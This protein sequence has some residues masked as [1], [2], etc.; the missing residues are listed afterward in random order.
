MASWSFWIDRGGTFTDTVALS[1]SG[2]LLSSKFLSV[3]PKKYDDAAVHSIRNFLSIP[4][5]EKI[6]ISQIESIKMGT[7]VATNALLERRGAR[8][9]L[10]VTRGFEDQLRLGYQ[11]RPDIFARQIILPDQLYE[12]VVTADERILANGKITKSLDMNA[13]KEDLKG[14][15]NEGMTSCAIIL[16]HGYRFV[17]HEK[18]AANLANE[19]GF[20]QVSVSHEVNPQ[21]RFVERGD[22][23]VLDAYLTPILRKY[24]DQLEEN[25]VGDLGHR[26]MFMQSNGGLASPKFF[27]GKDAVLSG[28]AG[29]VVG[30]VEVSMR[31]GEVKIIGFDM[32]GTST[33][34]CHFSGQYE[35]I[36]KGQIAGVRLATPMM[37]IHTV[38]AGGGS[39]LSYSSGRLQVGPESA[40][41]EPGPAC[42]GNG[43]PLTVTDANVITGRLRPEFFPPIFG[44]LGDQSLSKNESSAAIEPIAKKLNKSPEAIAEDWLSVAVQNMVSAIKRVSVQRGYNVSTYCLTV[45][46]G[47]G[48]Q[49]ACSIADKLG[50]NRCLLHSKASLL[51]AY[52]IGLAR[53]RRVKKKT[54]E[55]L[56]TDQSV[57][58]LESQ[59][60]ILMQKLSSEL[61]DQG[62]KMTEIESESTIFLKLK[63]SDTTFPTNFESAQI[64]RHDFEQSFEK[65]FGFSIEDESIMIDSVSVEVCQ[66]KFEIE[67]IPQKPIKRTK[68]KMKAFSTER[69]FIDGKWHSCKFIRKEDLRSNDHVSGPA[70]IIE[71]FTSILV[72]PGWDANHIDDGS[73]FLRKREI[74]RTQH[75]K[76]TKSKPDPMLL[77]VFN[78][79][80]MSIAEQMGVV[81]ENTA[82]SVTIKERL[83]FSCAVFDSSGNLIANAPHMPVHVGSMEASIKAVIK[84]NETI[85]EQDIFALNAPYDGGTHLPDITVVKPVFNQS[86]G[87]LIFFVASRGHHTDVGGSTPGSMPPDS[88][89]IDDEGVYIENFKLVDRGHFKR[90]EVMNIFLGAKYPARSIEVNI[91]DLRAQVAA[92]EKGEKELNLLIDEYGS[93]LVRA[94][95]HFVSENASDMVK[96]ILY[97]IRPSSYVYKMDD[98]IDGNQ[99]QICVSVGLQNNPLKAIIDFS[100]TTSQT[101][102][103][104]NAPEPVTRAAVLYAIRILVGGEIPMNA[105]LMSHVEIKLPEGTM[106]SPEYPAA[107]IAGN[108]ETSQA[109]TSAL[110]LAF[111]IQAASQSTMNNI[112]WGNQ[113]YQYYETI[114]GGTGAGLHANGKAYAGT[115]GVHS[116]MTNSRLTDPEVLELRFPVI[117][118]EFSLRKGSG[119]SGR[120]RGGN[121][122]VRKT[123]FLEPMTFSIISGHRM[124]SPPGLEGGLSGS[125][126]ETILI[127][128]NGEKIVLKAC[129]KISLFKGD[130]IIV[131]TPGGGGYGNLS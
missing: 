106:L 40:G 44:K 125:L 61:C 99:R 64:M 131:K 103:N 51:S 54:I 16:M 95:T 59:I 31:A 78:N 37:N 83:D 41:A 124:V 6:P 57:G 26:L 77:E 60:A 33:D 15:L 105:G 130:L 76:I 72:K 75:S 14:C 48:G 13:L 52:G 91:A 45:F 19:L 17:E 101:K 74:I 113:E 100:G 50:I 53:I 30:A 85:Q 112:T 58:F 20:E 8:T 127:R 111:G 120:V 81:L 80:F 68:R 11:N 5:D 3:N 88:R 2:Q 70:I 84:R 34:V 71:A 110:L 46:G 102:T 86:D 128:K 4:N 116:H 82:Q 98:D 35:R 115:S 7:T 69:A 55:K 25:F 79:V 90:D 114:C 32:G 1:P 9:A 89:H 96:S 129:D 42:Y 56:L 93:G 38:A 67:D 49:F 87:K 62:V 10:V 24:I 92:C 123:R 18:M 23:T 39:I 117:L 12:K 122:V 65:Q 28:P 108:V 109:V 126:G 121:G 63:S 119:G 107:V 29:G 43:G 22:T 27:R 21:I 73:I 47:A 36:F 66:K 97:S 118:E 104:F 94:Y